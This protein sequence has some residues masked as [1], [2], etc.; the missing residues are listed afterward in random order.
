MERQCRC[1]ST[2]L[3]P[4]DQRDGVNSRVRGTPKEPVQRHLFYVCDACG[5]GYRENIDVKEGV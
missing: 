1:G 3:T 4:T 5:A 2:K